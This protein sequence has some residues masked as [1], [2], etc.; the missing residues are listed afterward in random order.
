MKHVIIGLFLLLATLFAPRVEAAT[1]KECEIFIYN[2]LGP[3]HYTW[4]LQDPSV[5]EEYFVYYTVNFYADGIL[6]STEQVPKSYD[7]TPPMNPVKTSYTFDGWDRD[8]RNVHE[9]LTINAKWFRSYQI[10]FLSHNGITLKTEWLMLGGSATPPTPP[11]RAGYEFTGWSG[12]YTNVSNDQT[13]LATYQPITYQVVFFHLDGR[14]YVSKETTYN[15]T[16][17]PPTAPV[18]EGKTFTQWSVSTQQVQSNLSVHPEYDTMRYTVRFFD[19]TQLL[20]QQTL[21]HGDNAVP[22]IVNKEGHLFAGWSGAYAG[23]TASVDLQ[24][25]WTK[26]LFDVFFYHPSGAV[27]SH[28][29]VE[30]DDAALAPSYTPQQGMMFVAWDQDYSA[31]RTSLHIHPIEDVATFDVHFMDGETLLL[32][33]TLGYGESCAPF[34]PVKLGHDFV[35]WDQSCDNVTENLTVQATFQVHQYVVRFYDFSGFVVKEDVVDHGQA[36]TPPP[37]PFPNYSFHGWS[38]AFD[39]VTSELSV[40]PLGE[41]RSYQAVFKNYEGTTLCTK[42]VQYND[43]VDC[44]EPQ[45]VGYVFTGWNHS[46]IITE[47][48]TILAQYD[49]LVFQV[50]FYVNGVLAKREMVQ[51]N[52]DATP[53]QINLK[54]FDFTRWNGEYQ[55]VTSHQRVDAVVQRREYVVVFKAGDTTIKEVSVPHGEDAVPPHDVM[56]KGHTFVRWIEEYTNVTTHRAIHAE[57][58]PRLYSVTFI[59]QGAPY[60]RLEVPYL[61]QATAPDVNVTGYEVIGWRGTLSGIEQ[62][63][64]VYAILQVNTYTVR[65]MD[66]GEVISEQL[67]EHG[68]AAQAPDSGEWDQRFD[69]VT[70]NMTIQRGAL[71][72]DGLDS[73]GVVLDSPGMGTWYFPV[74]RA[75]ED[76]TRFTFDVNLADYE[77]IELQLGGRG[78]TDLSSLTFPSTHLFRREVRWFEVENPLQQRI[79]FSLRHVETGE[80]VFIEPIETDTNTP[81]F[82]QQ[83]WLMVISLFER[84]LP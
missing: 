17:I 35:S 11:A 57:F 70:K 67:V 33:E 26:E 37:T 10:T 44:P 76:R 7:A 49:P 50:D 83:I 32:K 6:L 82:F 23:I 36:A 64:E 55:K 19:G 18:I 27:L 53:P 9:D 22:P 5:Y 54:E 73:P 56:L 43:A 34:V 30:Y 31:I 69:N 1:Q 74:I 16:V 62:D 58:T 20:K 38:V 41:M 68:R 72:D 48:V 51:Y 60:A 66:Q 24:A 59:V 42:I 39:H 45:R 52:F 65:F 78:V 28:Q 40:H 75:Q 13:I 12:H 84:F 4:C 77:I 21:D 3:T 61:G 29:S 79:E 14:V 8:F 71:K 2:L 47:D 81:L 15:G 80:M 46:L 25:S 63:V